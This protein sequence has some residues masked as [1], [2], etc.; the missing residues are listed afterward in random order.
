MACG[1]WNSQ[2]TFYKTF[3][4]TC[5][6]ILYC[7]W[8]LHSIELR[9]GNYSLCFLRNI[10]LIKVSHIT[11]NI[12]NNS[13]SGAQ[14][15]LV[16]L[17][18][19]TQLSIKMSLPVHVPEDDGKEHQ[20]DQVQP[21]ARRD[22]HLVGDRPLVQHPLEPKK[23]RNLATPHDLR[24]RSYSVARF[25]QCGASPHH[26]CY[27]LFS[28]ISSGYQLGCTEDAVSASQKCSTKHRE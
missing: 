25:L 17:Y 21:E 7:T 10:S 3:L 14:F 16:T 9:K 8:W 24:M 28:F 20:L 2:K 19:C 15:C 18:S 26:R 1:V 4:T 13:I 22:G 6:P 27:A 12:K 11:N 5:R 23:R